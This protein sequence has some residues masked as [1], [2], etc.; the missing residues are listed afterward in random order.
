[1]SDITVTEAP[2]TAPSK[3]VTLVKKFTPTKSQLKAAAVG[4]GITLIGAAAALA[5]A[6]KRQDEDDF[7]D[8]VDYIVVEETEA[9]DTVA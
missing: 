9:D 8:D 1:M 6:L 3:A 7:E 4:A 2:V 5:F